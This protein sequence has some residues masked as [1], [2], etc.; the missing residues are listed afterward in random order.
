MKLVSPDEM[1]LVKNRRLFWKNSRLRRQAIVEMESMEGE[2]LFSAEARLGNWVIDE[3]LGEIKEG[4]QISADEK[5][6]FHLFLKKLNSSKYFTDKTE[7][8][9][10]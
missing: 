3:L 9:G 4:H 7:G 10:L 5:L 8:Q 2:R 1:T 6:N